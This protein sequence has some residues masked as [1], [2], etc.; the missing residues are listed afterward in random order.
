MGSLVVAVIAGLGAL[1]V[2]RRRGLVIAAIGFGVIVGG[3]LTWLMG[4][5][6][7]RRAR[8]EIS[9][10]DGS[11][12]EVAELIVDKVVDGMQNVGLIAAV[13]GV[14]VWWSPAYVVSTALER[15]R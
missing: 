8:D 12:R 7:Q 11:A 9:G 10:A 15:R 3:V 6:A 14:V 13:A 2:A 1:V 4:D 5:F